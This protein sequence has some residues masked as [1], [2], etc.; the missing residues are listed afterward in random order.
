MLAEFERSAWRFEQQTSYWLGY[1]RDQFEKFLT[2]TPESPADNPDLRSWFDRVRSWV[3][4]GRTIGRVR[5]LEDPPTDYQRWMLWMDRW[6]RNAGE[7]I[8]YL[9]RRAAEQ[10]SVIPQA[11]PDD[12]WLFDDERLVVTSFDPLGKPA[13]YVLVEGEAEAV[14]LA[15][16][17]RAWAI[18]AANRE[19]A[20]L[21][22]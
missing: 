1:E 9:T 13:R 11:G 16:R 20:D 7:T 3:A 18:A 5:I 2:G 22:E 21:G 6:N 10:A 4:Q 12:W 14:G 15:I 19:A 17:W 8:Q